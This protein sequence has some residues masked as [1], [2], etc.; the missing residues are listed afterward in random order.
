MAGDTQT[1][2]QKERQTDRQMHTFV[3]T[4]Y[5]SWQEFEPKTSLILRRCWIFIG[6]DRQ[7][8]RQTKWKTDRQTQTHIETDRQAY[9]WMETVRQKERQTDRQK[10]E[11]QT[12]VYICND[13]LHIIAGI[14]PQNLPHPKKMLKGFHYW[15]QASD[16]YLLFWSCFCEERAM[17]FQYFAYL[18]WLH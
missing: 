14:W 13:W 8:D 7:T 1:D 5:I 10:D 4:G 9:W 11:R 12:N 15:C 2:R 6:T 17:Q 18:V 3:M 16:F